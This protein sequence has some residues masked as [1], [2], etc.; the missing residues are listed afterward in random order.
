MIKKKHNCNS[1]NSKVKVL[2]RMCN[3][4][5]IN[6][7]MRIMFMEHLVFRYCGHTCACLSHVST[8]HITEYR[9]T[10]I[11]YLNSYHYR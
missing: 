2:I 7:D 1:N 3:S 4:E 5:Y 8:Q 9:F 6:I 11:L 10:I